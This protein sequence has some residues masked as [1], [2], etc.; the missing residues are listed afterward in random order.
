MGIDETKQYL[1][2]SSF[3]ISNHYYI[4]SLLTYLLVT[5]NYFDFQWIIGRGGFGKVIL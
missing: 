4:T 5:R 3:D 1:S 2:T